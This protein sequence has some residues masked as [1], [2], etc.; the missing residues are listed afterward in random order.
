MEILRF[1][2]T[3]VCAATSSQKSTYMKPYLHPNFMRR[4]TT[5][6]KEKRKEKLKESFLEKIFKIKLVERMWQKLVNLDTIHWYYEGPETTVVARCY[7]E[8]ARR[9]KFVAY[10]FSFNF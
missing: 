1:A 2:S 7:D 6:E 5:I 10:T 3:I 9:R 4:K 8:Q